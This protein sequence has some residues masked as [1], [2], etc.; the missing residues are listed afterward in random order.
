[1]RQSTSNTSTSSLTR[2]LSVHDDLSH[3]DYE[4]KH[5][6]KVPPPQAPPPN[7]YEKDCA[8]RYTALR[9]RIHEGPLYTV[10]GDGVKAGVKRRASESP[11]PS[12][13]A[14]VDPFTV[15]ETYSAKY[16]KKGK[17]MPKLD[18]RP[19][20]P[21]LF[22]EELRS[23]IDPEHNSD[24]KPDGTHPVKR[25]RLFELSKSSMMT[26]L[27]RIEAEEVERKEGNEDEEEADEEE[28]DDGFEKEGEKDN[29]DDDRLSVM[30]SD[31]EEEDDDYNAEQYFDNGEDDDFGGDDGGHEDNYYE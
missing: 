7:Q 14:L 16:L 24:G 12:Q 20:V 29:P 22:P 23:L 30:S 28:E 17:A 9:D 18:A 1:M 11:P 27:Q 8:Q 21:S 3:L 15:T 31:S 26:K 4:L 25:R 19:Y 10:L 2:S 6:Q 13:G 5:S